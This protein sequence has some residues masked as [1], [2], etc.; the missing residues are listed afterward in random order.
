MTPGDR[1][2]A[3]PGR[4]DPPSSRAR[5]G[6]LSCL[7]LLGRTEVWLLLIGLG[8]TIL[9]K[10]I[11][12]RRHDVPSLLFETLR[13]VQPD[14][15]FF[16]AVFGLVVGLCAFVRW[17]VAARCALV[18][19]ACAAGWSI[20]DA[21]W[22]IKCGVQL[23]PGVVGLLFHSF[24]EMWPLV[25]SN[26]RQHP[27]L[28]GFLLFVLAGV[29][30]LFL[31]RFVCPGRQRLV[32]GAYV[33]CFCT[34][35]LAVLL[36]SLVVHFMPSHSP[37]DVLRTVLCSSSHTYALAGIAGL[38][39]ATARSSVEARAIPHVGERT[40]VLPPDPPQHRPHVLIV[41]MESVSHAVWSRDNHG[42]MPNLALVAEQG[43]ELSP[44]R[45]LTARSNKAIWASLTGQTPSLQYHY[46]ESIL[47]DRPYEGLPTILKRMGYRTAHFEMARGSFECAPAL[48]YN[49]GFD[50]AWFRDNLQDPS[51]HL[52]FFAGDDCRMIDPIVQWIGRS[53]EPFFLHVNTS[54][55]HGPGEYELPE[56]FAQKPG[57]SAYDRY[58]QAVRYTDHFIGRLLSALAQ[59]GLQDRLLVCIMGDHGASFRNG[60]DN[61]RWT[62]YEEVLCAP[63]VMRWPGHIA[64][65]QRHT[66]PFSQ[67]DVTPTILRLLG[68]DIDQ[69][70]FEGRDAFGTPD[71]QRT[72][73]FA[74]WS[75]DSPAGSWQA[76]RKI[77][78]WPNPGRAFEY[79]LQLDPNEDHPRPLTPAETDSVR[80]G[81][82]KWMHGASINVGHRHYD[83][84]LLYS[85]WWTYSAGEKV[86]AYYMP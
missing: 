69:A 66:G 31:W 72:L 63:W 20:I 57:S 53:S 64:P 11:V 49:L 84:R 52:G 5:F 60:A 50:W 79:D 42:L 34:A 65:G 46:V 35:G 15:L 67:M 30:V 4:G 7:R 47:A 81:V 61:E 48:Y 19:S 71:P 54:V 75:F 25:E 58:V 56:S 62:P 83:K 29:V 16:L 22:L 85:H 44:A 51:A 24:G 38:T 32:R 76:G 70:G 86:R 78:Y 12:L 1:P 68:C 9:G 41:T 55:A 80:E 23:Q 18:L 28:G 82:L 33:R 3:P 14:L 73:R 74:S 8:C 2:T 6:G 43:A 21:A 17:G 39:D 45:V 37:P 10:L 59:A 40:I 77:V 13:V 26:L 36:L 27:F